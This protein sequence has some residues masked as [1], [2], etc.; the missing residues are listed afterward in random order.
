MN[1]TRVRERIVIFFLGIILFT[2]F[3]ARAQRTA[4]GEKYVST[5]SAVA[6]RQMRRYKIPASITLAQGLLESGAG[7]QTLARQGNNHFGIK[8]AGGWSGGR[9][10]K[11]DDLKNECFR[12]YRSAE[13]SYEDHSK[14]LLRDRYAS[15]FQLSITD[16]KGWANGLKRCGYATDPSYASKLIR[17][18]ESYDLTRFDRQGL[19][20]SKDALAGTHTLYKSGKLLY[21][22]ASSGDDLK[23]IG[24][25]FGISRRKLRKYNELTKDYQLKNGDIVYLCSKNSKAAKGYKYHTVQAGESLHT[26]A[27]KY[28]VTTQ[29]LR[30][31]NKLGDRFTLRAGEVLK[32]R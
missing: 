20:A 25:E 15:L 12:T 2:P 30:R 32:L 5:Y 18:I 7:Q 11:D 14:F 16:Y 24:K 17:I 9:M 1:K 23:T 3:T 13:D 22:I 8:C 4:A 6:I 29:S 26:I 21:V 10:Y 28:G 19:A 27:Q 31:R